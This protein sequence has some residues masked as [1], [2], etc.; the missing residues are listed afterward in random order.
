M[1]NGCFFS[2]GQVRLG[3]LNLYAPNHESAQ[4]KFWTQI[5]D[6]LPRADELCIGGDFNMLEAPENRCGGS[7]TTIHGTKLAAWE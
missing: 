2:G 3:L 6:A 1:H 7:H 5:V 4:A